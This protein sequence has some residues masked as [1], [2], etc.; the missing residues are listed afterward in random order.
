[1]SSESTN[2]FPLRTQIPG[3]TVVGAEPNKSEAAVPSTETGLESTGDA[4]AD[5]E[6]PG[7][8]TGQA[9]AGNQ[10]L[11]TPPP[12][13]SFGFSPSHAEPFVPVKLSFPELWP[14]T[15]VRPIFFKLDFLLSEAADREQSA[16]L[17]LPD[18]ER[19]AESYRYDCRM[20]S[21]LACEPPEGLLDFPAMPE[22]FDTDNEA[23]RRQL[24]AG[25]FAYMLRP[26][27][28]SARALAFLARQVMSRFW[29]RVIPRDYL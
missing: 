7:F 24:A 21:L 12:L 28:R 19:Q 22:P 13:S 14:D 3:S 1:M 23:H 5:T 27:D 18:S 11:K 6:T 29:N 25:V 15:H 16:F 8:N 17:R 20:L 2:A 10:A 26:G 9:N 4:S